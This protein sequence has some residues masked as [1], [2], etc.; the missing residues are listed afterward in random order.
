MS[1][2]EL[3]GK[4]EGEARR[5]TPVIEA[6]SLVEAGKSFEVRIRIGERPHPNTLPHHI[7]SVMVF[8]E[9]ENRPPLLVLRYDPFP[10]MVEPRFSFYMSLDR[11]ATLHVLS[12]C[13][14]HGIW[15]SQKRIEII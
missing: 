6:P 13:T 12:T 14:I 10:P 5:H 9:L 3:L 8:L 11:S 4:D 1:M 2:D 7:L 15:E